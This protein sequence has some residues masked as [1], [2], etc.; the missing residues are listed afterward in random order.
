MVYSYRLLADN[1]TK[2]KANRSAAPPL[3]PK[4][5]SPLLKARAGVR[6]D[7]AKTR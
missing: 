4:A 7:G 6:V 2:K 5:P 3:G 1:E